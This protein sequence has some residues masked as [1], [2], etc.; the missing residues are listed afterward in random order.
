MRNVG[1]HTIRTIAAAAA[2][3]AVTVPANAAAD[4]RC[5]VPD[6]IVKPESSMPRA[7]FAVRRNQRLDILL[8]SGSPSQTGATKGLKSYPVF[9]EQALHEQLPGVEI[10][11]TVRTAPRRSAIDVLPQIP[12]M[13][14]E[15]KPALV[16]WQAG[17]VESLRGIPP[18]ELASALEQGVALAS[19]AG[20]D[21]VLLNMQYSPRMAALMD[22]ASYIQNM[23]RVVETLDISMFDRFEIMRHWNESGAFDLSSTRNDGLFERIHLCLG[24]LLADFVIRGASLTNYKGTSK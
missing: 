16:I 10:R 12:L 3:L 7:S 17:T 20:A 19:R 9:F 4:E 24:Q 14:E 1:V 13:M 11:L 18:D 2:I 15:L 5:T 23:R 21:V 22:S 6:S 8:L